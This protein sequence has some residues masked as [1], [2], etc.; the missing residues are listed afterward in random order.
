MNLSAKSTIDQI[1][2]ANLDVMFLIDR[3]GSMD[4]ADTKSRLSR[5]NDAKEGTTAF[6]EQIGKF[7]DDGIDIILYNNEILEQVGVAPSAVGKIFT[8]YH[9]G[10]GTRMAP[11]LRRA[12][13]ICTKRMQEKNQLIIAITDG[14]PS[15]GEEVKRTIIEATKLM[16]H[17]SQMAV[18][19]VHIGQDQAAADFLQELD[20]DL[21]RM[22]AKFDIV[23]S[24]TADNVFG[25]PLQDVVNK[26]FND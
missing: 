8:N 20:D 4:T 26:A 17:N 23:D 16:T 24:D 7:D 3:S 5:W 13:D 10:G 25:N 22:G 19:F 2:L 1:N 18:L 6:A 11:P 9:P 21:E 14:Q 15:D 12:F